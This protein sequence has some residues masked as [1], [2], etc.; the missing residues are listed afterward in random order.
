MPKPTYIDLFAGCG[1]LSYGLGQAGWNGL[2]AIEK[3]PM[4]FATFEHNLLGEDSHFT[5]PEW[6][7]QEPLDIDEVLGTHTSKLKKLRGKVDLVA[8]GPP[9]QGFS[10]AG[11]REEGD[12]RNSLVYSYL[13]VVKL[14]QPKI[15]FL[16]NVS[17]ITQRFRTADGSM[18]MRYS[19]KISDELMKLGYS[20][21]EREVLN[22]A[23]FGLPQSRRRFIMVAVRGET[24]DF[25]EKLRNSKK[26]FLKN[27]GLKQSQTAKD[28]LSD[29]LR[30]HGEEECP[31][32]KRFVSGT[33]GSLES[34]F[35][36]LMRADSTKGAVAD[37]HRFPNHTLDSIKVFKRLIKKAPPNV[38]LRGELAREYGV[39]KRNVT[40]LASDKP[41]PTV[42]SIP[43]DYVHYS[44]PRIM[45]V[46]ECARLQTFPDSFEFIG[47]YTTGGK[48]R[49]V[50]V[51]RYTQVGNAI[52]PL[53]AELVGS[54]LK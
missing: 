30:A 45:T 21:P 8:G 11:K 54:V 35:Q 26:E 31:D 9:C 34:G 39:K 18:G 20:L 41:S 6:L 13:E 7:P 19:D 22:L 3:S 42:L 25:F 51:P 2:F 5:W 1:G 23:D 47:K 10:M 33:Y 17:G 24:V 46:R 15:V 32:S 12:K 28:A 48:L 52:P 40:L 49:R 16:E 43:D 27:K 44:E 53:F 4:A 50:E 37:S 36:R 38:G 29:L 14:V